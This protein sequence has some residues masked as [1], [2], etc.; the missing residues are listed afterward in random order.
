MSSYLQIFLDETDEELDAL[1]EALLQLESAP[2]DVN[3][4]NEAFRL[5]HSLKGSSACSMT[6]PW[7]S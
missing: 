4:L 1:V 6:A 5:L 7:A 3:A 2:A